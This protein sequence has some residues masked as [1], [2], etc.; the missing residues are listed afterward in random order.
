MHRLVFLI[1]EGM[2][3]QG[4]SDPQWLNFAR[5]A[6]SGNGRRLRGVRAVLRC[7]DLADPAFRFGDLE[8][9]GNGVFDL[10]SVDCREKANGEKLR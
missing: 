9:K 1:D 6:E 5:G 3:W 2:V 10:D 4:V 8:G 7:L